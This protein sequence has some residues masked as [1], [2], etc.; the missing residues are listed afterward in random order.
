MTTL[1]EREEQTFTERHGHDPKVDTLRKRNR[2]LIVALAIMTAACVALGTWTIVDRSGSSDV[3]PTAEIQQLSDDYRASWNEYDGNAF[4]GYVTDDYGFQ[5][6]GDSPT[7][8]TAQASFIGMS[9]G[10][11]WNAAPV[12]EPI[13]AGDGPWYVAT[14]DHLTAD[15]YPED[16]VDG[17]SV[18]KIVDEGGTLKV[19]HHT[20][21]GDM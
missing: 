14:V 4:L 8:A 11:N 5:V 18:V 12:G 15:G 17:V 6:L 20:F 19:A 7:S 16:G 21:I 9:S 13:V 1:I 2:F 3:A 10:S